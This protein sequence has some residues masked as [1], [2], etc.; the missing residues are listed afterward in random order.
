MKRKKI[1]YKIPY[2]VLCT[3]CEADLAD[4]WDHII[5]VSQ[6][7]EDDILNLAP[8][9]KRCNSLAGNLVFKSLEEKRSYL[10]D[11]WK[12]IKKPIERKLISKKSETFMLK[13]IK[14]KKV[15][16]KILKNDMVLV[17]LLPA[18]GI[19]SRTWVIGST[20]NAL[21]MMLGRRRFNH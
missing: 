13:I 19:P 8:C 10:K 16:I 4:S 14:N 5:P 17:P 20:D 11:R 15:H 1:K 9:C 18:D 3:Y 6:G 21:L 7:G 12:L 2:L